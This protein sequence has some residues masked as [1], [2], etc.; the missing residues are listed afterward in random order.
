MILDRRRGTR[1]Y[2]SPFGAVGAPVAQAAG[3]QLVTLL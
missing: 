3:M 2:I 1:C